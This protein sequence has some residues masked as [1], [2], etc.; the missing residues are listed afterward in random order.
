MG[1]GGAIWDL[2]WF[3]ATVVLGG[4]L[5]WCCYVSVIILSNHITGLG[6]ARNNRRE[7]SRYQRGAAKIDCLFRYQIETLLLGDGKQPTPHLPF[8]RPCVLHTVFF[9]VHHPDVKGE[10]KSELPIV[11]SGRE[12]RGDRGVWVSVGFRWCLKF[13]LCLCCS[14]RFVSLRDVLS[15]CL[16][17]SL[18]PSPATCPIFFSKSRKPQPNS[19]NPL[20]SLLKPTS[21]N[22]WVT[23]DMLNVYSFPVF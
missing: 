11:P 22:W 12:R 16:S 8:T 20:N 17:H 6:T 23:G 1:V 18:P 7:H 9:S 19:G 4:K 5:I 3:P 14:K 10:I 15:L 21:L 2:Q 13:W